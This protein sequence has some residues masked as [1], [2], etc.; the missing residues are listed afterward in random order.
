MF[1]GSR[2]HLW[3]LSVQFLAEHPFTS[4]LTIHCNWIPLILMTSLICLDLSNEHPIFVDFLR[5]FWEGFYLIDDA[6]TWKQLFFFGI[7]NVD[8]R[9]NYWSLWNTV[10]TGIIHFRTIVYSDIVLTSLYFEKS[11]WWSSLVEISWAVYR[12]CF[13]NVNV[14]VSALLLKLRVFQRVPRSQP[15]SWLWR[16]HQ[17]GC[18]SQPRQKNRAI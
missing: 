12:W 8:G 18:Q 5:I 9:G 10:S 3:L 14:H 17:V 11:L 13:L 2:C 16:G 7:P 1:I 4:K 15:C 6:P